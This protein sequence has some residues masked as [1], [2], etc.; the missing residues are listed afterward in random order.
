MNWRKHSNIGSLSPSHVSAALTRKSVNS[1][2]PSINYR[3]MIEVHNSDDDTLLGYISKN[4]INQAQY[5][6]DTVDNALIV[7]FTLDNGESSAEGINLITEVYLSCYDLGTASNRVSL[8]RT[9]TSPTTS[10]WVLF[11]VAMTPTPLSQ[12]T[13]MSMSDPLLPSY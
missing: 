8:T 7:S 1:A 5:G 9:R 12:L 2:A 3:A 6:Y 13:V 4:S 10:I 11:K